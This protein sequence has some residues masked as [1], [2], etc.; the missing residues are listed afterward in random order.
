MAR[1]GISF[2]YFQLKVYQNAKPVAIAYQCANDRT[3]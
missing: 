1:L 3:N 2:M